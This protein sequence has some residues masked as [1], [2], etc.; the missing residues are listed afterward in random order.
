[1]TEPGLTIDMPRQ[2]STRQTKPPLQKLKGFLSKQVRGLS[3]RGSK[4]DANISAVIT[5]AADVFS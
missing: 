2:V 4:A 1:M 5:D 3:S